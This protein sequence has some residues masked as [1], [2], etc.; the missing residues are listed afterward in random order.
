MRTACVIAEFDPLHNG[1]R[2]LIDRARRAGYDTVAVVLGGDFAQRGDVARYSKFVRAEMALRCGADLVAELPLP[3]ALSSAGN[4]AF[5]AVSEAANLGCEALFFG[6]ECGDLELLRRVAE[7]T[8]SVEFGE[9]LRA[10]LKSGVSYASARSRALEKFGVPPEVTR[11]PNDI[12]AAEYIRTG[13]ALGWSGEYVAV[14]R[15][16]APHGGSAPGAE[17]A[18]STAIREMFARGEGETVARYMPRESRELAEAEERG[19]RAADIHRLERAILVELRRGD[20]FTHLPDGGEGL[21]E[22]LGEAA[23]AARSWDELIFAAKTKRYT[24]SR[25]RRVALS[26][27]LGVSDSYLGA[28]P[29]YVRLLAANERG[30]EAA[31][32]ARRVSAVPVVFR[33]TELRGDP[34]FSLNVRASDLWCLAC[35][36][37]PPA[38]RDYTTGLIG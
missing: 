30:R 34:L 31:R 29:P 22:R 36:N 14:K 25:V 28:P 12:L 8:A 37:P 20:C 6:S 10:I 2:Y 17:Y 3:W 4:F 18:S 1:H 13:D 19:G 24:L 26:A 35:E 11:A 7:V 9:T 32:L 23:A 15:L 33:A 16:G 38:G 27:F 5:G 21:A